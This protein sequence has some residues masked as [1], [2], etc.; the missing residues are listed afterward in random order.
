MQPPDIELVEA[1]VTAVKQ[2]RKYSPTAEETLRALAVEALRQHKKVKPAVKA[3]RQR[4]HGIMAPYL[5]DPDYD[6]A[7]AELTAAYASRDPERG[8]AV[9]RELMTTHL[10]TRER[11]PILEEFYGAIWA[12][13]G[14]PQVLLDIA[15]GLN[16]L[17]VDWMGLPPDVAY[18]AY[19]IHEGRVAFLNQYLSLRGL[20]PLARVQ[21]VAL[22]PPIQVG[23]VALFLKEM[24]RFEPN[25]PGRGRVLLEETPV[26]Y[27]VVSFPTVSARGG[28]NLTARYRA[29][30]ADLVAGRPWPVT[31]LLFDSEVVFCVK[32]ET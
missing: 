5:G 31:A 8:R 16:P 21:D 7:A 26:R 19:D 3:V 4:L 30:M 28:R 25:Y 17:A 29:F 24:Q 23:D 13:T 1:V 20:P 15:C 11:L 27:F 14:R 10:S 32:R 2:S 6:R 12:V 22:R 9:C 18:Y